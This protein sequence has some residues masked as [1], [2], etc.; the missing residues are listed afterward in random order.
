M[1]MHER[2]AASGDQAGGPRAPPSPS[3]M[4]VHHAPSHI[5]PR[6]IM[7]RKSRH[8]SISLLGHASS[9]RRGGG[10][11]PCLEGRCRPQA[12]SR[13]RHRPPLLLLLLPRPPLRLTRPPGAGRR[14]LGRAHFFSRAL[15]SSYKRSRYFWVESFLLSCMGIS[16]AL[17]ARGSVSWSWNCWQY[18]C[19][20]PS[21]AVIRLLGL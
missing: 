12:A 20:R 14:P 4:Q 3:T 9:S 17:S 8:A 21:L 10:A 18:G 6:H 5:G 7:R 2:D 15:R 13:A 19:V 11:W 1:Q 16:T